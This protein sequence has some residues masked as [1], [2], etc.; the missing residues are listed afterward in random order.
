MDT[1]KSIAE[2][3]HDVLS[4]QLLERLNSGE[5]TAA[6]MNVAR[7]FLK[8]NG[9]DD[10]A[11]PRKPLRKLAEHAAFQDPHEQVQLRPAE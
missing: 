8:D 5:A 7:Q 1:P 2:Q 10:L 11:M 4:R 3:L 9:V 6:E